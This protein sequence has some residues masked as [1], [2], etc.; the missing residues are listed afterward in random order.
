MSSEPGAAVNRPLNDPGEARL[1]VENAVV[2]YGDL[3]VLA[4]VSLKVGGS[5]V[6]SIVGPSGC[7]KTTLL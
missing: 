3:P 4:D 5:E 1:V 2:R 6:V 7:G